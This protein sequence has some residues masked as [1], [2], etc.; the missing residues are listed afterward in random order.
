MMR[1]STVTETHHQK[2]LDALKMVGQIP[3]RKAVVA[4]LT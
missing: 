1:I 2:I 4:K 3:R